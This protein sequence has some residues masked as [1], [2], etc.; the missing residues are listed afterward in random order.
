VY[1]KF[2][3]I[4]EEKMVD[5]LLPH[6]SYDHAIDI[7]K[8]EQL[9]WSPIYALSKVELKALGEYL[10]KILY[11]GKIRPSKLPVGA[12]I[13]FIPKLHR[14]GLWLYIDYQDLNCVTVLNRDPLLFMNKLR[15]WVQGAK[16][17]SKIDLKS[18][19][20]LIRIKEGDK[21]K[22]TVR[23]GYSYYGYLLMPF[24][25]PITPPTFQ[26]MMHDILQDL[27]D[28]GI[29]VYIDNILIYSAED[30][31]HQCLVMDVL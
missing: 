19:Y 26:N 1:H 15:D 30:K 16:I 12:S 8:G 5:T 4:F 22:L 13:L 14:R 21:W 11:I 20:N 10:D 17:F 28:Q 9:P 27:I 3:S 6:H 29:V 2:L 25:I 18:R 31:E 7:Q 23:T 24:R